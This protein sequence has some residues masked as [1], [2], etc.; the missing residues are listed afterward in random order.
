MLCNTTHSRLLF[1]VI[2]MSLVLYLRMEGLAT[3]AK[4]G[5]LCSYRVSN[6]A[7]PCTKHG[8]RKEAGTWEARTVTVRYGN[9]LTV[10]VASLN[11]AFCT[12]MLLPS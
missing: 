11:E 1:P 6:L 8:T 7:A 12:V 10:Q 4:L 2:R 3:G 9:L 5:A